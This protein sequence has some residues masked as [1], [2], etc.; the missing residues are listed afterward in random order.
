M[1]IIAQ[2]LSDVQEIEFIISNINNVFV[3]IILF[4]MDL[5]AWLNLNVVADKNGIKKL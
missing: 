5:L 2:E 3:L 1:E 4:G